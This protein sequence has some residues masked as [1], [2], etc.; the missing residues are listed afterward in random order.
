MLQILWS[1]VFF[2]LCRHFYGLSYEKVFTEDVE[3]VQNYQIN[4]DMT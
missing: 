4:T 1:Y 2:A 3:K